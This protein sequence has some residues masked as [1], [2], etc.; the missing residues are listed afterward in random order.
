V[1]TGECK[2]RRHTLGPFAAA[3]AHGVISSSQ[4]HLVVALWTSGSAALSQFAR[5]RRGSPSVKEAF[6]ADS[7]PQ[8]QCAAGPLPASVADL[9]ARER[10]APT[11]GSNPATAVATS[12]GGARA[13]ACRMPAACCSQR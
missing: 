3:P 10:C 9:D 12:L 1:R 8:P 13:A 5:S 4:F 6:V 2:L 11:V 7:S